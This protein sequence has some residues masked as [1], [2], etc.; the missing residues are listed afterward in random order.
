MVHSEGW[1][2]WAT[3][4]RRSAGEAFQAHLED[5][6]WWKA[7]AFFV[8][9][10]KLPFMAMRA[11]DST[12]KG[13]MGR[14]YDHMLQLTVDVKQLLEGEDGQ[15]LLT[16]GE[17]REINKFVKT[18][19]DGSLPCPLHVVGRILNPGNQVEEIFPD[20]VEC[21][22]VFKDFISRHYEGQTITRK[23]VGERRATLVLQEGLMSFL[24]LEGSFGMPDA[25]RDRLA[26]KEGKGCMVHWWTWHGTDCPELAKLACRVLTQPVSASAC[27]RNW[28]V[29][30]SVHT[31]WRNKLGS[32]KLKDL[33]YIAHN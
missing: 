27:E 17:E 11:T 15:E 29:W 25:I 21:T 30:D 3:G 23:D 31:A 4:V 14:F 16:R 10:M 20:D 2:L 19:W 7:A 18:R 12:A 32:E 28:A 33:V 22:K 6:I 8:K 9:L 5:K 26:V 24:K 13:M 1:E